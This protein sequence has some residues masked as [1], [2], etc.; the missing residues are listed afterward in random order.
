MKQ[1]LDVDYDIS[2]DNMIDMTTS[3]ESNGFKVKKAS[4]FNMRGSVS[5]NVLAREVNYVQEQIFQMTD[6]IFILEVEKDM[7]VSYFFSK[8][9]NDLI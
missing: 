8:N 6:G 3:Q 1:E 7:E 5:K 2:V 9:I 4:F